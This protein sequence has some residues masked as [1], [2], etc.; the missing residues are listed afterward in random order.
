MAKIKI[1]IGKTIGTDRLEAW[2]MSNLRSERT[3]LPNIYI[4]VSTKAGVQH[5]PRIKVSKIK[6]K[7]AATDAETFSVSISI[8]PEVV[9][10]TC[11][12]PSK[13]LNEVFRWVTLNKDVLLRFW[14]SDDMDYEDLK[15]LLKRL[16]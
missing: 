8:K 13:D 6:G 7:F 3:G 2:A 4:W 15:P 10:G 14:E 11:E 16:P 9:D 5:G 1:S 12:F